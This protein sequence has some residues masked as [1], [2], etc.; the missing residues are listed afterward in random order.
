MTHTELKV[1]AIENG[2]VIDHIAAEDLFK[3]IKILSLDQHNDLI[4]FG[5]NLESRKMGKKAIVKIA[6]KFFEKD[7]IDKI[8]IIAPTATLTIIKDYKI[9]EKR[10]LDIPDTIH[11]FI[12]CLNPNCVTNKENVSTKFTVISKEPNNVKLRCHYCEKT[13]SEANMKFNLSDI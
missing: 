3:V 8:S 6:N 10:D 11:K 7:D 2:T 12:K 9:A 13:T 4:L 1:S 5:S